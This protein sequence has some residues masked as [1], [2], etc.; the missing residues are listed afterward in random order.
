MRK[1]FRDLAS[2][3]EAREVAQEL[4]PEPTVEEVDI[5][6]AGGMVLAETL[7]SPKDVPGFDRSKMDG[8]ALQAED[9][10]DA[11]EESPA[12]LELAGSVSAGETPDL[13]VSTGVAVGIATG[14]PI[15]EGAD[16]VVP[17]ERTE[18]EDDVVLVRTSLAPGDHVM[19]AG[20]D[21]AAGE[22]ALSSGTLLTQREIGLAAATGRAKLPVYRQ[23]KVA[24]V[25]TGDELV[26]PPG[27]LDSGQIH[28]SNT[29]SVAAAVE[30]AG[31]E[32][33]I[34]PHVGDDYG[35]M[36]EVIAEAAAE[37]DL[38]LSS[39]STSASDEDVVYRVVE[40]EGSLLLHGVSLKPG[41]P[42]VFGSVDETSFVGLPGNPISAL[43]VYR[44][45]VEG[46]IREAAGLPREPETRTVDASFA[47]EVRTEGGRTRILPVGM[48][49]DGSGDLLAY[50]V[51]RGSGATTSLTLADGYV[52]VES[53]TNYVDR[54]E[55]VEVSVFADGSPP[56]VLG[57]G[58]ADAA[59]ASALEVVDS[60]WLDVSSREAARR[61]RDGVVDVAVVALSSEDLDSLGVS[62]YSR[63]SSYRRLVGF[64]GDPEDAE[65]YGVVPEGYGL[66]GW[67]ED[68]VSTDAD[69]RVYRS[70]E[71][72]Y[73]AAEDGEV[74]AA[75][76]GADVVPK[77]GAFEQRGWLDVDLLVA[78]DRRTKSGVQQMLAA[79]DP[80]ES[81]G[82]EGLQVPGDI[83]D[84]T[85]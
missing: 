32:A 83:G 39:G 41:R 81:D 37:C 59:V 2:L 5:E 69:V 64:A 8:Y 21:V 46:M 30:S 60:R 54:G 85:G 63:H 70:E 23:P 72:A 3:A 18:A 73:N 76:V 78:D 4:T 14:A 67:F 47:A 62:S 42:T 28:D 50:S 80:D 66:R 44:M 26:R 29:Y 77:D 35:R 58:E 12:E 43:S 53:E 68:E 6:D 49:E 33:R 19:Y 17:V 25:S 45:F 82:F 51:D 7:R 9:T 16:A 13:S 55:P 38:V 31:G 40:D 65:V 61:L 15:P 27:V 34:Y 10:Y 1:E 79:V 57:A 75:A 74:D 48:V 56:S 11:D 52:T 22:R 24:V 36:V 20:S 84:D 71:G